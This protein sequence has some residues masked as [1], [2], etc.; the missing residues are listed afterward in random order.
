MLNITRFPESDLVNKVSNLERRP[1]F[2][3]I[4]ITA[5]IL[6]LQGGI[7][8]QGTCLTIH[9]LSDFRDIGH[10]NILSRSKLL[11]NNSIL[12]TPRFL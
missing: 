9:P 4:K 11:C 5:D 12:K 8:T 3:E 2:K 10:Y 7:R 6:G 1:G